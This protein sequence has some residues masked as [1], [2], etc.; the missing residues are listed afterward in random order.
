MC[1]NIGPKSIFLPIFFENYGEYRNHHLNTT[2]KTMELNVNIFSEG[3][4]NDI[5]YGIWDSL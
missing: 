1:L 5:Y 3:S 4:E 2:D